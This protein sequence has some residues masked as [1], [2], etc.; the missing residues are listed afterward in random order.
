MKNTLVTFTLTVMVSYIAMAQTPLS[1]FEH[2]LVGYL[3]DSTRVSVSDGMSASDNKKD[4][5]TICKID[6]Y[7]LHAKVQFVDSLTMED[8]KKMLKGKHMAYSYSSYYLD[9]NGALDE[10]NASS[11]Y[12]SKI[13]NDKISPPMVYVYYKHTGG[14]YISF[15][16][17]EYVYVVFAR[18]IQ[19]G[20]KI[21]IRNPEQGSYINVSV[22]Q[23][24]DN[25][26]Y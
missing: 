14:Y 4:S 15:Y 19:K 25:S 26:L 13:Y 9:Y 21:E 10:F 16:N 1:E 8:K 20:D 5:I 12:G 24:T 17:G 18:G 11:V 3:F 6:K 23:G 22:L 2:R 7:N